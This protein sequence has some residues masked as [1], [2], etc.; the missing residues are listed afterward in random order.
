ME[1]R[2]SGKRTCLYNATQLE[3]V[4]D[5]MALQLAGLLVGKERIMVVGIL[6]RGAPL[7]EMLRLRLFQPF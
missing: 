1:A 2:P 5:T 4:L 6:R 3:A 7:A